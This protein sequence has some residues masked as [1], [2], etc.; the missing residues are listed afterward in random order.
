MEGM[1]NNRNEIEQRLGV[2]ARPSAKSKMGFFD[3]LGSRLKTAVGVIAGPQKTKRP[4]A[5]Q[6][7]V[8]KAKEACDSAAKGYKFILDQ[9]I[10][11]L[12]KLSQYVNKMNR[13]AQ[14]L[15]SAPDI[16]QIAGKI[17]GAQQTVN[18]LRLSTRLPFS[19]SGSKSIFEG[20]NCGTGAGGFKPGNTCGAE[21]GKAGGGSDAKKK[22]KPKLPR[23]LTGKPKKARKPSREILKQWESA[24]EAAVDSSWEISDIL[25]K[26][27][28][29]LQVRTDSKAMALK[30]EINSIEEQLNDLQSDLTAAT[31]DIDPGFGSDSV[32]DV[33]AAGEIIKNAPALLR[34]LEGKIRRIQH[35]G[36]KSRRKAEMPVADKVAT[37][38]YN[39]LEQ[40]ARVDRQIEKALEGLKGRRGR[41]VD[42]ARRELKQLAQDLKSSRQ[43]NI[44]DVD[45][46]EMVQKAGAT[47]KENRQ[48]ITQIGK[49]V[50]DAARRAAESA[51][52]PKA[53]RKSK[54]KTSESSTTM[55]SRLEVIAN[56]YS[57]R[58][59]KVKNCNV[60]SK[61]LSYGKGC[62][63]EQDKAG[64]K[65]MEKADKAVSDKIRTLIKEGKPQDQAV[66][67]AL[68][69]KRR[70][71]L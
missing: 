66:A 33:I 30:S 58:S 63:T 6:E 18:A 32:D 50:A 51:S 12:K 68:D 5:Y 37:N 21:D 45:T 11:Q 27:D 42:A 26:V 20:D 57:A 35:E 3:G 54:A 14:T 9:H 70:G 29:E 46:D 49:Q 44:S 40:A 59:R 67:I 34:Q 61:P 22:K 17:N 64:L 24:A 71:E 19:R 2:F 52:A 7:S 65:L 23:S 25:S 55:M 36:K 48:R 69:M 47:A 39:N 28:N 10:E 1:S 16:A 43:R 13:A 53:K 56:R 15:N 41:G 62:E 8:E 60:D 38:I 4:E 31:S